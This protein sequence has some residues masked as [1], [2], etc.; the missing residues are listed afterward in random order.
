MA[1]SLPAPIRKLT[2][3]FYIFLD[4]VVDAPHEWHFPMGASPIWAMTLQVTAPAANS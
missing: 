3:S 1:R 2:A 4:G